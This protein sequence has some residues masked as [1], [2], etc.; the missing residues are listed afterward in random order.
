MGFRF[1]RSIRLAPGIRMNFGK[2]GFN[3]VNLGNVNFGKRGVHA[4]YGIRGTGISY[5]Q[6]ISKS[7]PP[8]RRKTTTSTTAT[9]KLQEDG[10]VLF[11]DKNENPLSEALILAG[12]RQNRSYILSWLED[13]CN[14]YN[15]DIEKLI[16]IHTTTPAPGDVTVN[17]KPIEPTLLQYGLTS[18]LFA[19]QKEKTDAKNLQLHK[20][21]EEALGQWEKAE[22][23][24]KSNTETMSN[25]LEAAFQSI[26]WPRETSISFE[27]TKKGKEVYLD[28]DLPEIEDMPEN[29]ARV[30]VRD[31][32]LIITKRTKAQ[33]QKDYLIHVHAVALR[34]AGDVFAHLPSVDTV[35]VSGYSQRPD[36][37]TGN[38]QNDYLLSAKI[39]RIDWEKINFQN[40][41]ALDP[42]SAFERFK[43]V[44]QIEK[45]GLLAKIEPF[46]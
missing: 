25:V 17:P 39:S 34:L 40:L 9:L 42:V 27:V 10:S 8:P 36:K 21:F 15:S 11:V 6:Q 29:I 31:L 14:E 46:G 30:G 35:I 28:I 45:N 16:R 12:K 24:L 43:V 7:T 5:R 33:I 44:R 4:S 1:R 13:N 22:V 23:D 38:I 37:K 19:G 18:R 3:S 41:A 32:K 26:E 20:E 2:G